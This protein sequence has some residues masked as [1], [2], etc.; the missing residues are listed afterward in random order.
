MKIVDNIKANVE[1]Q[2][3][4]EDT[5]TIEAYVYDKSMNLVIGLDGVMRV[6]YLILFKDYDDNCYQ[7]LIIDK[8]KIYA[9]YEK[10]QVCMVTV[11]TSPIE[12][13]ITVFP[14]DCFEHKQRS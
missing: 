9:N 4:K 14:V 1:A 2:K 5:K 8:P 12:Y 3:H 7:C 6:A 10:H 11:K 13:P